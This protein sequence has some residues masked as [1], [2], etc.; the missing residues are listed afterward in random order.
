MS[1]QQANQNLL[2]LCRDSRDTS[3]A[4]RDSARLALDQ[5]IEEES[6]TAPDAGRLDKIRAALEEARD[7][8]GNIGW[9][10]EEWAD[11]YINDVGWLLEQLYADEDA[12]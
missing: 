11:Q 6:V 1:V 5:A 3:K 7:E 12:G 2:L 4:E 8:Y 10:V 9:G